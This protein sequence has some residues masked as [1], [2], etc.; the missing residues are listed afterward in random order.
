[1]IKREG[2]SASASRRTILRAF[3]GGL[4]A[5]SAGVHAEEFPNRTIKIVVP[6]PP[7]AINDVLARAI[8]DQMTKSLKQSVIVENRAGGNTLIGTNA[9]ATSKPDGYTLL[10]MPPA[11]AIN[12]SLVA[13]L[14]YDS[15]KSFTPITLAASAPLLLLARKDAP[16]KNVKDLVRLAKEK[17]GQ[18]TFGSSGTG[19]T[20]H[21]MGEML[22]SVAD[23][24][25]LH[26][27]YKGTAPVITDLIGGQLDYTFGT[28]SGAAS[29][30]KSDRVRV[31]AITSAERSPAFKDY[32]TIAE[33]GYPTYDIE[34]WWAF[35]APANTPAP[36]VERLNK[37]IVEAVNAP[38]L[39]PKLAME[40]IRARG[41]T[42]KEFEAFLTKEIE[43]WKTIIK[44]RGIKLDT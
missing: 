16:A 43:T 41:T 25:M 37:A 21:L 7:G 42:P 3:A 33:S 23:I 1:M 19:G 2:D 9:V 11:H 6:Y 12:A 18:Y 44:D 31:L 20:A 34:G 22:Q 10:Q 28:Y 5:I 38:G 15:V 14:P 40:G 4:A 24:K 26:V 36:I 35:A 17:P 39:A 32:P 13:N 29:A 27:P 30:L 8:A